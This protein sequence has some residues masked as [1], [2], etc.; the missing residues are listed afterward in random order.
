MITMKWIARMF[1]EL[2]RYGIANRAPGMSLA[3]IALL[4]LGAVAVAVKVTAPF[5]YT[6][7]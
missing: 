4:L 7:F 5:I 1:L 3:V 2:L 6:L